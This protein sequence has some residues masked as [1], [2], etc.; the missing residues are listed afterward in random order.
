MGLVR[1]MSSCDEN[2]W[3][4]CLHQGEQIAEVGSWCGAAAPMLSMHFHD[5]AQ[6]TFV[7]VGSRRFEASCETFL[8]PAGHCV[9]IPEGVPHRSLQHLH[10]GTRCLNIY[11]A[12]PT[13]VR[14]PKVLPI[15]GWTTG[16]ANHADPAALLKAILPML[17]QGPA[18]IPRA[19]TLDS[20]TLLQVNSERIGM[21]ARRHGLSREAF[22]R[23]FAG[24]FGMPPHAYRVVS[25]LNEARRLLRSGAAVADIAAAMGFADQSHFGRHFRR[26][27]GVTPHAY[28]H[29]MR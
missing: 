27:F 29:T 17:A 6:I 23:K 20:Q 26:A 10:Q 24:T 2:A 12:L 13:S 1:Y 15:S 5:E 18:A 14:A 25:R 3:S 8:V 21:I 22:T 28:S 7:L 19:M 9:L 4:Y 11:A 16:M